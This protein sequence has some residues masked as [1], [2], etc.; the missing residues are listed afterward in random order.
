MVD[1]GCGAI[2]S[3][4][5]SARA[6]TSTPASIPVLDVPAFFMV[7]SELDLVGFPVGPVF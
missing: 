6:M 5:A 1:M 3:Q 2:V 4:P 7:F